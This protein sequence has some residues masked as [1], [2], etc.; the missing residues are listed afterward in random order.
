MLLRCMGGWFR[1]LSASEVDVRTEPAI[2]SRV[3]TPR[4]SYLHHGPC[5]H[6]DTS[7][8]LAPTG[9]P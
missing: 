5:G 1:N 2:K 7:A 8:H 4:L 3:S 6:N 9:N